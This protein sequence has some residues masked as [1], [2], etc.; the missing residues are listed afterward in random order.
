MSS[1]SMLVTCTEQSFHWRLQ[2]ISIIAEACVCVPRSYFDHNHEEC[3]RFWHFSLLRKYYACSGGKIALPPR[4]QRRA[5]WR[6][7]TR[8]S[9]PL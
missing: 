6:K 8:E 9:M 3:R 4:W 2:S 7:F 1:N 5:A